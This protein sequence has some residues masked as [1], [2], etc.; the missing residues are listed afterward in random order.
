[1]ARRIANEVDRLN[2]LAA[3]QGQLEFINQAEMGVYNAGAIAGAAAVGLGAYQA[4]GAMRQPAPPQPA[5][6]EQEF[7]PQYLPP[8]WDEIARRGQPRGAEELFPLGPPI[9]PAPR[10]VLQE[11]ERQRVARAERREARREQF[12]ILREQTRELRERAEEGPER[13]REREERRIVEEERRIDE[14]MRR[15]GEEAVRMQEER[16]RYLQLQA[17]E[18]PEEQRR[19][20]LYGAIE[21]YR[22][23]EL[24]NQAAE[25]RT[26]EQYLV[27]LQNDLYNRQRI[28]AWQNTQ[29]YDEYLD[30][31][32]EHRGDVAQRPIPPPSLMAVKQGGLLPLAVQPVTLT[33]SG[34]PENPNLRSLIVGNG[35]GGSIQGLYGG[36]RAQYGH[37]PDYRYHHSYDNE[38]IQNRF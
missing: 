9:E 30:R 22:D 28:Q 1:M 16:E 37:A 35:T 38:V 34:Y 15:R 14:E 11:I 8:N 12:E 17:I 24:Y 31:V 25:A 13:A 27:A 4:V 23:V 26:E 19:I 3:G 7:N 10:E 29:L 2:R 21:N 33:D 36:E 32:Q 5:R 18:N 20:E 6:G